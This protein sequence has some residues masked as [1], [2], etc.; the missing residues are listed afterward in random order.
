MLDSIWT[1]S[2]WEAFVFFAVGLAL[3]ETFAV[4]AAFRFGA[5]L[6]RRKPIFFG[7]CAGAFFGLCALVYL[8]V[9]SNSAFSGVEG[10]ATTA[11]EK[12]RIASFPV[13]AALG[14]VAKSSVCVCAVAFLAQEALLGAAFA[15]VL[16]GS[17]LFGSGN[18]IKTGTDVER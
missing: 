10:S 4:R 18:R 12:L 15:F 11:L 5:D 3:W 9:V 1:R 16:R 6:P 2:P 13:S 8:T 7:T 17:A 14:N